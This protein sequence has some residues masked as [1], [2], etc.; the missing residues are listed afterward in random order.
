MVAMGNSKDQSLQ[1]EDANFTQIL[2]EELARRGLT[3]FG[4]VDLELTFQDPKKTWDQHLARFNHWIS[5]GHHGEMGYLERGAERRG[6]PRYLM[7]QARSILCVGVPYDRAEP[8]SMGPKYARYLSDP[9]YHDRLRSQLEQVFD[10]ANL[11][12]TSL[13]H[14]PIAFKVCVDTSAVLERTWGYLAGLGWIGK[15][16]LLIHPKLG[17]YFFLGEVL[18][19]DACQIAPQPMPSLCG[20]C[21]ACIQGCP[22]QAFEADGALNSRRCISYLT[23]EKRGPTEFDPHGWIAGC[24]VCQEVCPFN[25][26]PARGAQAGDR[27]H[28]LSDVIA[29]LRESPQE[30]RARIQHSALSRIKPENFERNLALWISS[31]VT[32]E[33]AHPWPAVYELIQERI[34]N[35]NSPR[36][37]WE[38]SL[39]KIEILFPEM[40]SRP[41]P[42]KPP[43]S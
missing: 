21:S 7:P 43:Q 36:P 6:D 38:T 20:H 31:Q 26:K 28:L 18:Y 33:L 11:R 24:D 9:D 37:L 4:M 13:G 42:Q 2:K 5:A 39:Q 23:L 10:S 27:S 40:Q 34:Q 14:S 19:S 25:R 12:W 32:R 16:S 1:S 8:E 35:F 22:T 29:L 30:Y 41:A 15:N 3:H 17:S